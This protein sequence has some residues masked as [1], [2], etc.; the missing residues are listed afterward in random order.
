MNVMVVDDS[1]ILRERLKVMLDEVP[2]IVCAGEAADAATAMTMLQ[3][4]QP[5]I[6]ILDIRMPGRSGIELLRDIK[7]HSPATIVIMLTNYPTNEHRTVC[8]AAGADFFFDKSR[9]LAAVVD[10][11]ERLTRRRPGTAS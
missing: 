2:G 6:V 5:D 7:R 3:A 10:V 1:P 9:E 8:E 4:T 11:L